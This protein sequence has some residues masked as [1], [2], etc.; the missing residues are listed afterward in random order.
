MDYVDEFKNAMENEGV[1][2]KVSIIADSLIHRFYVEGD[3]SGSKN[4]WYVF[5]PD[6]IPGGAFGSWKSGI[7]SKWSAKSHQL[8]AV[9]QINRQK[10][11]DHE[12]VQRKELRRIRLKHAQ[13]RAHYIWKNSQPVTEHPYLI[14]KCILPF[15]ARQGFG[16]IILPIINFEFQL[17]S[18]QFIKPN[19]MKKLLTA[20]EKKGNFILINKPEYFS[21]ILISEGFATG[22]T[23]AEAYPESCV[24]AAIDGGNLQQVAIGIR[25][26]FPTSKI[27][28]CADDDRQTVGNPGLTHGRKAAIAANVFLARPHWP[29]GASISIS[30][31]NDLMILKGLKEVK[32]QIDEQTT[33][34]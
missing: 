12:Y 6:N 5:Y 8:S 14:K 26:K 20:G 22:A 13:N 11:I 9:E 1:P 25:Q 33:A 34:L 23:L 31:F 15:V 17:K 3:S 2:I 7:K 18:L 27:I 10:K 28:I 21:E 19:G 32:K 24:L 29:E 16:S 4:G 30:D